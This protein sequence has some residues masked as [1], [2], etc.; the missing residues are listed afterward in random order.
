MS[1]ADDTTKTTDELTHELLLT[2]CVN[3]GHAD[4]KQWLDAAFCAGL[5]KAIRIIRKEID[6]CGEYAAGCQPCVARNNSIV[7]IEEYR[8]RY[9]TDRA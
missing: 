5:D 9:N 6:T 1:N 7:D 8:D 4:L 3:M 2:D